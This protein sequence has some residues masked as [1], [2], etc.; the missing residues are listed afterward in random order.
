VT[1]G[2]RTYWQAQ[3]HVATRMVLLGAILAG[4][5]WVVLRNQPVH[6]ILRTIAVGPAPLAV[7]VDERSHHAFVLSVARDNSSAAE[8]SM[9]DTTTGRL[10]RAIVVAQFPQALTVGSDHGHADRPRFHRQRR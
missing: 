9:V 8:V 4:I 1:L 5:A 10:Q 3:A 2:A 6:P 7:R